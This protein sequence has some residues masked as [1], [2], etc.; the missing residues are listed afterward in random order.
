LC[1]D[2]NLLTWIADLNLLFVFLCY[3]PDRFP[4]YCARIRIRSPL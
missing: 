1:Y 3:D 2:L 4:F